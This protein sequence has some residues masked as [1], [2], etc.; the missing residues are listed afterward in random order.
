[1]A[2]AGTTMQELTEPLDATTGRR[3]DVA[4]TRLRDSR[5]IGPDLMPVLD[6]AI[7][8]SG[9]DMGTLQRFDES[10]DCLTF[11][12]SRGFSSQALSFFAIVRRDSNTTCAAALTRRMRVFVEDVSTSY[13]FV[14]TAQLDMLRADGIAAVQ[15]TPLISS[16]GRLWGV[17][18]TH[19]REVQVESDF[20]HAPLDRLAVQIADSLEAREGLMPD[21]QGAGRLDGGT[22]A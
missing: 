15:S 22:L 2:R 7:A 12:A 4:L 10:T 20:E 8:I 19:F 3:I 16:T 9:A 13:L 11:V 5:D 14:G 17:V 18:S 21:R 6:I 1:M